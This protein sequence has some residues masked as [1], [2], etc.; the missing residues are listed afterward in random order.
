VTSPSDTS[1]ERPNLIAVTGG[2]VHA[3]SA[4]RRPLCRPG[5]QSGLGVTG[6]RRTTYK[7]TSKHVTCKRCLAA[8]QT[9]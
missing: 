6:R 3:R 1:A 8:T 7:E 2:A 4:G 5:S 9:A